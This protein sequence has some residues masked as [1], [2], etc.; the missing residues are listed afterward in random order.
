MLERREVPYGCVP[1]MS[2]GERLLSHYM[3]DVPGH[4][5][6]SNNRLLF[7]SDRSR[8]V[9]CQVLDLDTR[10]KEIVVP[11]LSYVGALA[12]NGSLFVAMRTMPDISKYYDSLHVFSADGEKQRSVAISF[13]PISMAWSQD[14][15]WMMHGY[16]PVRISQCDSN[17]VIL[18][19][20]TYPGDKCDSWASSIRSGI[21][22]YRDHI[23]FYDQ[24]DSMIYH[25][26]PTASIVSGVAVITDSVGFSENAWST[27]SNDTLFYFVNPGVRTYTPSGTLLHSYPA[28][29]GAYNGSVWDGYALWL[30]HY[31]HGSVR[32]NKEVI[33][34]FTL[35]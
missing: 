22:W 21:V 24:C 28:P 15:L 34:R 2:P 4:L 12:W 3:N 8:W 13:Y 16:H 29:R 18:A 9:R 26:D 32:S 1:E 27:A 14:G 35:E 11:Y 20:F 23:V 10:Y 30:S 5:A 7:R 31:G 6:A 25:V 19:Q 33:S 17:G